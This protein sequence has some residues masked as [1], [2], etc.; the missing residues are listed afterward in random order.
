[1]KILKRLIKNFTP[2]NSV[3][4]IKHLLNVVGLKFIND[5]NKKKELAELLNDYTNLQFE[6]NRLLKNKNNN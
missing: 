6:E 4:N 1:M 3:F 5:R 2:K